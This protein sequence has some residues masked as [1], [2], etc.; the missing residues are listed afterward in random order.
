[1]GRG[2]CWSTEEE[3]LLQDDM[4]ERKGSTATAQRIGVDGGA[5]KVAQY[6]ACDFHMKSMQYL[7]FQ[8]W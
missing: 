6:A 4:A 3:S 7:N 8:P 2:R 5:A 1:M